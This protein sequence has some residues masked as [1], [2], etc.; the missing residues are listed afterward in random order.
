MFSPAELR[1]SAEKAVMTAREPREQLSQTHDDEFTGPPVALLRR[2]RNISIISDAET[3]A[4]S[5]PPPAP[6]VTGN[7]RPGKKDSA[8][9]LEKHREQLVSLFW[10]RDL[11]LK[12]VQ[13]TMKRQHGLDV[14]TKVYNSQFRKWGIRKNLKR[15]EAL[16]LAIGQP[17]GPSSIFWPDKRD[18]DY[19]VRI[20]PVN[21]PRRLRGPDTLEKVEA[22]SYYLHMYIVANH[23]PETWF[24]H[25][26][27]YG[28]QG[29]FSSLFVRGLDCLAR[30]ENPRQAFKD[31]NLAF[32]QLQQTITGAHPLA[33]MRLIDT[34]AAFSQYTNSRICLT[35]CHML[36]DHVQ[37]LS[38]IVHG[39]NHPLNHVWGEALCVSTGETP[40]SFVVAVGK[41]MLR[42]CMVRRDR[43]PL[44]AFD[45]AKCVPS[46]ARGL[47]E[48]S[49][50][51]SLENT[52]PNLDLSKAQ[53]TRLALAELL[54]SQN[55]LA[56]GCH[57]YR[58]AMAF[59][60]DDPVRRASKRFWA[61]ELQWR[62][63]STWGSI[64]TMK[65]ALACAKVEP[66]DVQGDGTTEMLRQ[67]I[68]GVLNRRPSLL[69]T[70]EKAKHVRAGH[71]CPAILL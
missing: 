18:S 16:E 6:V 3:A 47:D 42:K 36:S 60:D 52:P 24:R 51:R 23:E 25:C 50:R 57:F 28:E 4:S 14:S 11:P 45:I 33:Y 21:P 29:S 32:D 7:R 20:D 48:D 68:E 37:R 59:Q 40:E 27:C 49:L 56:E 9:G 26:P 67:E 39:P 15:H 41:S 17:E 55:S 1:T 35:V 58:V 54:I 71:K 31:I 38:I 22:A 61:A 13:A 65:A 70:R 19:A 53:E 46:D 64:D 62:S 34:I 30:H 12:E 63:G 10:I 43:C 2:H 5:M 66:E 44:E 8:N 69:A